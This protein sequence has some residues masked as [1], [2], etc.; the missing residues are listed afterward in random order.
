MIPAFA[1]RTP[2]VS[3]PVKVRPPTSSP[4]SL[5]KRMPATGRGRSIVLPSITPGC[6]RSLLEIT[7]RSVPS[8]SATLRRCTVI[9][10][11]FG[12][13]WRN[14]PVASTTSTSE[15]TTA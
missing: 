5:K 3:R 9:S 2:L 11:N 13:A 4:S 6:M 8:A 7:I 12:V 1:W 10:S 15:F 14:A